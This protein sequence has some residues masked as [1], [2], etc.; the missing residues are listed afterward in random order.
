[1]EED[2]K[3]LEELKKKEKIYK[4]VILIEIVII[5]IAL[6]LPL[7]DLLLYRNN[8]GCMYDEVEIQEFNSKFDNYVGA[9]I[10][11]TQVNA[12]INTVNMNNS[13]TEY[14]ERQV[15][16]EGDSAEMEI[17]GAYSAKAITGKQYNV[18]VTEYSECGLIKRI[19][20]TEVV[21]E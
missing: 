1:M 10:R 17:D 18:E 20:I 8:D 19:K 14:E 13:T 6:I 12:L 11:G 7:I 4:L 3:V 16:L 9:S 15:L 2:K 5:V 21:E